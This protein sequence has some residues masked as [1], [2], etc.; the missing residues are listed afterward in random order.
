LLNG[1][2]AAQLKG[3]VA[4]LDAL[5]PESAPALVRWVS[6]AIELRRADYGTRHD[7]LALIGEEIATFRIRHGLAPFDDS[8]PGEP[9]TAFEQ[10]RF[11]LTGVGVGEVECE[12]A[13]AAP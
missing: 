10:I 6:R 2:Y 7:V 4:L 12:D 8:L 11:I 3:L 13:G 5:T 1:P 9:P